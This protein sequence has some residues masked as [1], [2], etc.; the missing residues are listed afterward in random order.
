ML[1]SSSIHWH[2]F[3]QLNNSWA[4]G[5]V[6]VSQCPIA[7]NNSFL[8]TFPTNDQAGTF[9]YH[10]HLGTSSSLRISN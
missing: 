6:F 3:F 10:S 4:D 5:V 7:M 2:G 8:Y 1:L 9:W